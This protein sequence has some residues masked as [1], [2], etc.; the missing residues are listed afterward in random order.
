MDNINKRKYNKIKKLYDKYLFMSKLAAH[1]QDR[2]KTSVKNHII[3]IEREITTE[4]AKRPAETLQLI[5]IEKNAMDKGSPL[6]K[7]LTR[8][9]SKISPFEDDLLMLGG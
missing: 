3:Y 8:L 9:D 4:E 1:L 5:L 7:F 2:Q 6:G